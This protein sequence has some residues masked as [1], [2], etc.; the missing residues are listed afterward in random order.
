M[1]PFDGLR[2]TIGKLVMVPFDGLRVT[3]GKLVMVSLSN[4]G[5]SLA[6]CRNDRQKIVRPYSIWARFFDKMSP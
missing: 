3:I 2:V 1:V 6:D 4:H 5:F